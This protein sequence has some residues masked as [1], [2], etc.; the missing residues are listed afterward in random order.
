MWDWRAVLDCL[1]VQPG[2]LQRRDGAFATASGTLNANIY[3]SHTHLDGLFRNLLRGTLTGKRCAFATAFET[4]RPGAGPTKRVPF[5]VRDGHRR[6][7]KRSVDM[8][9][10]HRNVT[11]DFSFFYLCHEAVYSGLTIC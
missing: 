5:G 9:N 11:F 4:A 8:S 7:V 6:V 1:H 10:A 2:S 3:V